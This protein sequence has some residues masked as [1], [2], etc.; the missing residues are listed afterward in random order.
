[1][2]DPNES[3]P[4]D[5]HTT[6]WSLVLAAAQDSGKALERLCRIYWRPLY[7]FARRHGQSQADAED[8]VQGFIAK[9]LQRQWLRSLDEAKGS[10]RGFLQ[11]AFRR[12]M[13]DQYDRNSSQKRGGGNVAMSLETIEAEEF[14]CRELATAETPE[15]AY[16]KAWALEVFSRARAAL[17]DECVAAGR[18]AAYDAIQTGR[19]LTD[20]T[21][22]LGMTF[23][24]LNSLAFRLRRRLQQLIRDEI[25]QTVSN[26]A[27]LE[28]E[29]HSL[30]RALGGP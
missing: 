16:E 6:H 15:T 24:A 18:D 26:E 23:S 12:Y 14:Y 30:L 11:V 27:D 28:A 25:L 4:V 22:E 13:L 20:L 3:L 29:V 17:R 7:G 1:M 19:P 8:M 5:F 9:L 2:P 21:G 10:F